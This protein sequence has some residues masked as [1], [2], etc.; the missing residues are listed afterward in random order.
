LPIRALL[1]YIAN[2]CKSKK[3]ASAA[4]QV[5][6]FLHP[7]SEYTI[8][9]AHTPRSLCPDPLER[10]N[11]S[12]QS[13]PFRVSKYPAILHQPRFCQPPFFMYQWVSICI[14]YSNAVFCFVY[15]LF[16]NLRIYGKHLWLSNQNIHFSL[17]IRL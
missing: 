15:I 12:C 6:I 7:S 14:Q 17:R 9:G 8:S 16:L 10:R 2:T 5:Y 11:Y 13:A 1:T 4:S 3:N